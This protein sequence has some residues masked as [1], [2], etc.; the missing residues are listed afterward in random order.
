MPIIKVW[1]TWSNDSE[2]AMA[3]RS[4]VSASLASIDEGSRAP[5]ALH[6]LPHF[7]LA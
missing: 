3:C 7:C 5:S 6:R 1:R 2:D 4:S